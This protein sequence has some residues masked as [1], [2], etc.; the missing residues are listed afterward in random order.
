VRR[1]FLFLALLLC[2]QQ[3]KAITIAQHNE[4]T[5]TGSSGT[6]AMSTTTTTSGSLLVAL[7]N[8]GNN[9]AGTTYAATD[10]RSGGSNTYTEFPTN[11]TVKAATGLNDLTGL[12]A[13][14]SGSQSSLT[15]TVTVTGGG[16][17][18]LRIACKELTNGTGWLSSPV[19]VTNHASS[20]TSTV[21]PV[22]PGAVTPTVTGEL[23]IS[24]IQWG[25]ITNSYSTSSSSP[26]CT[27]Q[28][29]TG[30]WASS[31]KA[32]DCDIEGATT[33]SQN[34]QWSW[35]NASGYSTI[36]ITFKVGTA[37]NSIRHQ[38]TQSAKLVGP[39]L[40]KREGRNEKSSS[41]VSIS[42]ALR[43]TVF[44]PE[45]N[46]KL[47]DVRS[48]DAA[49]RANVDIVDRFVGDREG[50]YR[51]EDADYRHG[52]YFDVRRERRRNSTA[53]FDLRVRISDRN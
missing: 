51:Y 9:A 27:L 19:D 29:G 13:I 18:T 20:S 52:L 14:N 30:G 37:T 48:S 1:F 39:S 33:G 11:G 5:Q 38:V 16:S 47:V 34:V 36:V 3:A 15:I 24:A 42:S 22:G 50:V 46:V 53:C 23:L 43:S 8:F 10:D 17:H 45:S 2:A 26:A 32:N 40:N 25:I 49:C 28:G 31:Q 35:A 44:R 41:V 6:C 12:W 21:G 4:T 7:V